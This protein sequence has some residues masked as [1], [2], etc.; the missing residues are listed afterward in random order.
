MPLSQGQMKEETEIYSDFYS[1]FNMQK[2]FDSY[3]VH[4]NI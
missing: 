1:K 2:V 3:Y 4:Y